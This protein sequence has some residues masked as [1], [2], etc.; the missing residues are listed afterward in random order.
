M[1]KCTWK[2]SQTSSRSRSWSPSCQVTLVQRLQGLQ[3]R[4]WQCALC[5]VHCEISPDMCIDGHNSTYSG[6]VTQHGILRFTSAICTWPIT[7]AL[8]DSRL[9]CLGSGHARQ[10]EGMWAIRQTTC[11]VGSVRL[12]PN[13]DKLCTACAETAENFYKQHR[14]HDHK[15]SI[16]NSSSTRRVPTP[17]STEACTLGTY[18]QPYQQGTYVHG[19]CTNHQRLVTKEAKQSTVRSAGL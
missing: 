8:L 16:S 1:L 5:T 15:Q 13:N 4:P 18:C 19:V 3:C 2:A 11:E 12:I 10:H 6:G 17:S 9:A 14:Q 7:Q